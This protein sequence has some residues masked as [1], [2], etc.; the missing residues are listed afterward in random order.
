MTTCPRHVCHV[1]VIVSPLGHIDKFLARSFRPI[2]LSL[3][4]EP[5]GK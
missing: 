2:P 1:S 3:D 5:R 4:A